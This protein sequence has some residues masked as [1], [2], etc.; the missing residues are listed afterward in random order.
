[1]PLFLFLSGL[2]ARKA[3]EAVDNRQVNGYIIKKTRQLLVPFYVW[4]ILWCVI[5]GDNITMFL[6]GGFIYWYLPTLFEFLLLFSCIRYLSNTMKFRQRYFP[7][8]LLLSIFL[9]YQ[10]PD[11][12]FIGRILRIGYSSYFYIF[13]V[14]G[15]LFDRYLIKKGFTPPRLCKNL[16]LRFLNFRFESKF[17]RV[18]SFTCNER[19]KNT[20]ITGIFLIDTIRLKVARW[21]SLGFLT[22]SPILLLQIKG[23]YF[24]KYS[25]MMARIGM[26][27]MGIYL[28]H[29][30][31]V[32][33][34]PKR[35]DIQI[36]D[37]SEMLYLLVCLSISLIITCLCMTTIS[38]LKKHEISRL[39]MLGII[40]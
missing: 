12:C 5:K 27:T 40:K 15:Y 39:L 8:L 6:D 25:S 28:I 18:R 7:L 2:F 33:L 35:L 29:Y 4:M 14:L 10:I 11:A 9:L 20:I 30:Y 22:V 1:M 16:I 32:L 38:I 23:R 13:F 26:N 31:F 17:L 21:R 24:T 19:R 3:V 34:I 36:K 37:W